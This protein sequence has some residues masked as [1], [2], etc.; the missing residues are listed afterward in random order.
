MFLCDSLS[1]FSS[2]LSLLSGFTLYVG[3][4]RVFDGL[5]LK[6]FRTGLRLLSP[7]SR[8]VRV[9][10]QLLCGLLCAPRF[11]RVR[12]S[13]NN[14]VVGI[15]L[16]L[17]DPKIGCFDSR[18][19]RFFS[20]DSCPFGF[21]LCFDGGVTFLLRMSSRVRLF[22]GCTDCLGLFGFG[23][24]SDAFGFLLGSTRRSRLLF[25]LGLVSFCCRL[26]VLSD[27]SGT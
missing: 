14:E 12:L 19:K 1:F 3:F 24:I 10:R 27:A 4:V 20:T 18:C 9:S 25:G 2:S 23:V 7:Q 16:N 22:F 26:L 21:L 5:L 6:E 17:F 11:I 15:V 8:L 13:R